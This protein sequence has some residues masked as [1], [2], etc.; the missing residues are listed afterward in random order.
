MGKITINELSDS[1][2]DHIDS[3]QNATDD[4]LETNNKTVVGAINELFQNVDNKPSKQLIANAI[5][6]PLSAEDTFAEM[7]ND[8]NNLLS[9]F[10]TNMM[11][12]GVTVESGDK[13]KQLIDKIKGLTEGEGNK[14][15]Q[16][17]EG[18]V[19]CVITGGWN[20]TGKQDIPM[21][22]SFQPTIVIIHCTEFSGNV[23][24]HKNF[25]VMNDVDATIDLP[26]YGG[27]YYI[28]LSNITSESFRVTV[29]NGSHTN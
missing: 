20:T 5:G 25:C 21:N 11:I 12:S 23:F 14:G 7:S 28:S 13:F 4:L 6:E 27:N 10:K 22:L 1:L 9:N 16:Y 3:K 24:T 19:N 8:I 17:A 2:K 29:G 15:I 26:Y 18:T